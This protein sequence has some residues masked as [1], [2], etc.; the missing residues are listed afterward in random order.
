MLLGAVINAVLDPLLILKAGWGTTGAAL[1]TALAEA[2]QAVYLVWCVLGR[3]RGL[4][5]ADGG[6]EDAVRRCMPSKV[7]D[8][9]WR[10]DGV[11]RPSDGWL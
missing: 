7:R 10:L 2:V 1:A 3:D 4:F 8:L 6:L 11:C 5:L 9:G